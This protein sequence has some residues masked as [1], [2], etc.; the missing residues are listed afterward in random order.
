M[1]LVLAAVA[2]QYV[3][4]FLSYL[5][6]R[7]QAERQLA[8]V[9]SLAQQNHRLL[10]EQRSLRDPATIT[11]DARTLGMVRA[12]ERAFVVTGLPNR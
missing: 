4:H 2:E 11:R 7:S 5:S 1:L 9:Q 8:V 10:A 6:I 12:G 3:Q